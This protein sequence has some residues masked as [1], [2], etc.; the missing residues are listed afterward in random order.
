[1]LYALSSLP[2][3][4]VIVGT[5]ILCIKINLDNHATLITF[6]FVNTIITL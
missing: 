1:M 6:V 3:N 5:F 4:V 2:V